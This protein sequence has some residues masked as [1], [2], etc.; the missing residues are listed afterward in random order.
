MLI[1]LPREDGYG[2]NPR[3]KNGPSLAARALPRWEAVS[4]TR[5]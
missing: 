2:V 5:L 3:A 1:H 4:P